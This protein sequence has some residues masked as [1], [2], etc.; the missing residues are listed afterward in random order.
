MKTY[1]VL[2][3][4][5]NAAGQVVRTGRL[6]E[7]ADDEADRLVTRRAI[8]RVVHT[9]AL[10]VSLGAWKRSP[11]EPTELVHPPDTICLLAGEDAERLERDG[12]VR[13]LDPPELAELLGL[14]TSKET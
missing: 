6:V 13:R 10:Y 11:I 7:L 1:R 12:H 9:P 5:T 3:D 14:P 2:R 4:F 8:R